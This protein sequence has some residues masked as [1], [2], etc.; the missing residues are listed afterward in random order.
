MLIV[1]LEW[2]Y[3]DLNGRYQMILFKKNVTK[4][5]KGGLSSKSNCDFEI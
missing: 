2:F 4:V 5:E 1:I 3:L